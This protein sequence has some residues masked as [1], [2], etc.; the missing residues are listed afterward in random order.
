MKFKNV[1]TFMVVPP[2]SHNTALVL[3]GFS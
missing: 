1:Q 3:H 2:K